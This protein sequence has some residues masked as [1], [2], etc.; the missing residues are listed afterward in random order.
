MNT[1]KRQSVPDHWVAAEDNPAPIPVS[2]DLSVVPPVHI[3]KT[4]E[5]GNVF[6]RQAVPIPELSPM[7]CRSFLE[8]L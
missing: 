1:T 7:Q 6:A 4:G 8:E 2:T 5:V 3:G